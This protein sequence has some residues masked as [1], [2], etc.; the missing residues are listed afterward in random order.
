MVN[1]V[2]GKSAKKEKFIFLA[3]FSAVSLILGFYAYFL[4]NPTTIIFNLLIIT[5][6]IYALF[7]LLVGIR[8]AMSF[9][10][11]L[12]KELPVLLLY[13]ELLL[14]REGFPFYKAV[15][16]PFYLCKLREIFHGFRKEKVVSFLTDP[17]RLF[18]V[19]LFFET[20]L[21]FYLR[22]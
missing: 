3:N 12:D 9:L 10:G 14:K 18:V 6:C 1:I 20:L 11:E 13:I 4:V 21:E 15:R 16:F 17:F 22:G 19:I 8:R 7:L 5:I 2:K